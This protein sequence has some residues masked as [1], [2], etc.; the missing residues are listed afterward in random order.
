[1]SKYLKAVYGANDKPLIING[2]EIPC[3]VLEDGSRVISQRGML[4]ALGIQAGGTNNLAYDAFGG[5]A[6]LA[7]FLDKNNIIPLKSKVLTPLRNPIIFTVNKTDINGYPATTLQEIVRAI[8]KAHLRGT[9]PDQY[10][11][12]GRNAEI[13]DDAFAKVGI[14]ALIDEATGYQYNREK[15]ALQAILKSY[16]SPELLPWQK[17]FPDEYYTE[18]FRLN[19]WPFTLKGIQKNRPSV[20]GHWTNRLIYDLLPNGVLKKLQEITPKNAEGK[21]TAKLHQSLTLD[22]GEPHLEKQLISVIT[23]MNVSSDWKEFIK[24]FGKKFQSELT[25]IAAKKGLKKHEDTVE[26]YLLFEEPNSEPEKKGT[27]NSLKRIIAVPPPP[28]LPRK[29]KKGS[30]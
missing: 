20:I 12:L 14:I 26:Q 6:R 10:N 11:A 24:L 5:A 17:R 29:N 28:R 22:I 7:I 1:M 4:K 3:Y 23:L 9:L 30:D 19:G 25:D 2:I 8:S 16:I 15:D 21:K 18:I 27:L 13:L